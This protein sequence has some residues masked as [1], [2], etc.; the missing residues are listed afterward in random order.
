LCDIFSEDFL[1]PKRVKERGK[2]ICAI[3]LPTPF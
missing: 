1:P 3:D 2:F